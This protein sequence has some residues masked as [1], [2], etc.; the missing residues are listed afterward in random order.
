MMPPNLLIIHQGALGDFVTL[1][2]ALLRLRQYFKPLDVLCQGQLGRLAV[3]LGLAEQSYPLEAARFATLYGG[4]PDPG[5]A[6][7]LQGYRRIVL[8]SNSRQLGRCVARASGRRCLRLR[9]KPPA[10]Q[11]EHVSGYV[12]NQL[13]EAGLLAEKDGPA[14]SD[15]GSACVDKL[16]NPSRIL[17]HPGAGSRRKRWPIADF[18]KVYTRLRADGL[19][20]EFVL[21][22]AEADLADYLAKEAT[23]HCRVHVLESLIALVALLRSAG[24]FI[25]ND[26]GVSHLAAFLDLPT[27]VIFGPADPRRWKPV[28]RAVQIVRPRL[29]CQPCFETRPVNC[30]EPR[31]L[32]RT[33]PAAVI[34]AFYRGYRKS[35][36][37]SRRY[38]AAWKKDSSNSGL[39]S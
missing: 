13:L 35:S 17:I 37:Q 21:G 9:S 11:I 4:R 32:S 19:K 2:P 38:P 18:F 23:L 24:G 36:G 30:S 1:F 5:A 20:P 3:F 31:C 15:P 6:T 12:L 22:P 25:G 34:R 33:R 26:A 16:H 28:G 10:E 39:P 14:L 8:F 7:L 29:D 27:T